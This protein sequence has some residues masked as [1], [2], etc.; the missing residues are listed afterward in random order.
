M[1]ATFPRA[2][3]RFGEAALEHDG[4]G[5]NRPIAES[6]SR[7]LE[8]GRVA[9]GKPVSTLPQPALE[10]RAERPRRSPPAPPSARIVRPPRR[11]VV[12]FWLP[13]TA[14][15]WLLAPFPLLLA[16]LAYLAPAPFRPQNPYAAVLAVGRVL[17]SLGGTV[18][19]VDTPDALVRIRLF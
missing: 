4:I 3:A 16:P 2:I 18:V 17:T 12:R 8:L 14:L 1:S 6:C 19:D 15:F 9:G 7:S 11:V 13:V 10:G 5:R